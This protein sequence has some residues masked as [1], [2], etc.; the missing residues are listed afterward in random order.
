MKK[1]FGAAALLALV[2]VAPVESASAQQGGLIGGLIGAGAGAAIGGAVG[3]SAGAA[4]AG[5]IIGGATG[6]I[7]GQ[8]ADRRGRYYYYNS[9]CYR[10]VGYNRYRAIPARYCY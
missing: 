2:S 8:Q 3:G 9:G 5:G 10:R 6:A 7:I 4:I 1:I